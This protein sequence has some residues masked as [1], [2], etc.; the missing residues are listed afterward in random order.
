MTWSGGTY[1]KGNFTTN[2]WTGDA[3]LGIGI[4]AGRHD[5]QDDD[6][7]AGINQCLNKD[8]SNAATGNLNAGAFR[9]T[10]LGAGT[11]RTDAA[12]VGQVQDGTLHWGSTSGGTAN[13]QTLTLS[14]TVTAY[15]AGQRFSF[16]AGFTNTAAA[17][18]NVNGAGAKNIFNAAT[19]VA[20]GAGE[21]VSGR[22]YEVIYDGT[23]FLL[24]ND[25]TP[26]QNGDYIWLGTTAG[27]ATAQTATATPAITAYK[28]GQKFRALIGTGLSSTGATPTTHTLNINSIGAK[29]IV[30]NGSGGSPTFGSFVAGRI[31]EF[32]YDG[33]YMV[34]T[35]D[36]GAWQTYTPIL[37]YGASTL[38]KTVQYAKYK[39]TGNLLHAQFYLQVSALAAASGDITVELPVNLLN[40]AIRTIGSG[41]FYDPAPGVSYVCTCLIANGN[42]D[43]VYFINDASGASL[44]GTVPAITMN[45]GDGLL[46]D[47]HYE[48]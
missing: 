37:R 12:Q 48:V 38:A 44:F 47:L 41:Y 31:I 26:I 25:V 34:I 39:R 22:A 30:H 18:L 32:V 1:K 43:R 9:V 24:L 16:L 29:T 23:Q 20:I 11:A 4:E 15:V 17:T 7:A 27:T 2:G 5:T 46:F 36:P 13:A 42:S 40:Y 6:F 35:N 19:G 21:V 8:G 33:T 14:P 10:N 28:A 3:S 45:I